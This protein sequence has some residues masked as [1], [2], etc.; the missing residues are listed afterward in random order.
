MFDVNILA[1]LALLTVPLSRARA[2]LLGNELHSHVGVSPNL[3]AAV[4]R[5]SF[6]Q[7]KHNVCMFALLAYKASRF[8]LDFSV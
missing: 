6:V 7:E 2:A 8:L 1:W 3:L 5:P 4:L